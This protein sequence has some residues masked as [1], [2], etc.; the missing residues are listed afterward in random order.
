MPF[1]LTADSVSPPSASNSATAEWT[2]S[3]FTQ[4]YA[5]LA[6]FAGGSNTV[7]PF[8]TWPNSADGAFV[9]ITATGA[10]PDATLGQVAYSWDGAGNLTL[11]GQANATA[12]AQFTIIIAAII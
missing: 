9:L 4:T 2:T 3:A 11:T 10:A 12:Q 6:I 7:S 1:I 8:K 5:G